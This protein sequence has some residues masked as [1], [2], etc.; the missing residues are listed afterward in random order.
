[1][2]A[3]WNYEDF[4]KDAPD[5]ESGFKMSL[6]ITRNKDSYKEIYF[7]LKKKKAFR[8]ASA[9]VWIHKLIKEFILLSIFSSKNLYMVC[10]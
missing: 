4:W 8:Q 10:Y 5:S 6:G 2:F 3:L 9:I 7:K 1:M